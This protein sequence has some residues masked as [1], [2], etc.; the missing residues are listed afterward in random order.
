MDPV[1]Q[2]DR[3]PG[4]DQTGD[5]GQ[6]QDKQAKT[7]INQGNHEGRDQEVFDDGDDCGQVTLYFTGFWHGWPPCLSLQGFFRRPDSTSLQL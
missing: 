3:A 4:Q 1:G 5:K 2:G 7:E 6:E